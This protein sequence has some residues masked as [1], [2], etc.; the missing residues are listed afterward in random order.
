MSYKEDGKWCRVWEIGVKLFQKALPKVNIIRMSSPITDFER[1]RHICLAHM[2]SSDP[3]KNTYTHKSTPPNPT[4]PKSPPS[5]NN[6]ASF[7]WLRPGCYVSSLSSR[8]GNVGI[9]RGVIRCF[10]LWEPELTLLTYIRTP[11]SKWRMC[12]NWVLNVVET[13]WGCL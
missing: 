10:H 11:I 4:T 6:M 3:I 8:Q 13:S 1:S 2:Y 7:C 5:K 9:P 12:Q